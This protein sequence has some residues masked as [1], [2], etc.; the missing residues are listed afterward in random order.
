VKLLVERTFMHISAHRIILIVALVALSSPAHAYIDPGA[1]AL[2][3][4]GLIGSFV[5][6]TALGGLYMQRI[7]KGIRRMMGKID[8]DNTDGDKVE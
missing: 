7:R 4:Q 5:A 3:V 6:V 2:I 8:T 1:G